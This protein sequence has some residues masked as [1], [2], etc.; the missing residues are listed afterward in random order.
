MAEASPV[1]GVCQKFCPDKE[2]NL[3]RKQKLLH[4]WERGDGLWPVKEYSR[5]AAGQGPPQP[6]SVRDPQ[7]LVECAKYLVNIVMRSGLKEHREGKDLLE[8]YDF[9]FD[10]FRAIR[11]DLVLQQIYCDVTQFIL[12]ICIRFYLV[13]GQLL[14]TQPPHLFSSHICNSHL[15]EC[16]KS[17][18]LLK[19]TPQK[20]RN[21]VSAIYL[22]TNLS[23]PEA[24][25]WALQQCSKDKDLDCTLLRECLLISEVY[26]QGNYIRFFK[27]IKTLPIALLLATARHCQLMALRAVKVHSVSYSSKNL[28]FPLSKFS[29]DLYLSS[30]NSLEICNSHGQTT[31]TN[32]DDSWIRWDKSSFIEPENHPLYYSDVLQK[33]MGNYDLSKVILGEC[34]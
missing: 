19:E 6:S 17:C 10:R 15:L 3:R 33:L 7:T 18:L 26:R 1:V 25:R 11:Q 13:F 24:I 22:L 14:S 4:R 5:P 8:L 27:L 34:V 30:E 29:S 28:K 12:T 31:S 9:L 21:E 2:S 32:P 16:S 23:S 20:L